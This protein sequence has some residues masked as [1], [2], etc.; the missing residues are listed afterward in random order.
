M[1]RDPPA[2]HLRVHGT[3]LD[4][5]WAG[6]RA[7]PSVLAERLAR[8][9]AH[10]GSRAGGTEGVGLAGVGTGDLGEVFEWR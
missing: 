6:G 8:R 10:R 9:E 2:T 1:P 3:L 7:G 4:Q 5:R